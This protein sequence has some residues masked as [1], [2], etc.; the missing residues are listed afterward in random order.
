MSRFVKYAGKYF[1]LARIAA[2]SEIHV[3]REGSSAFDLNSYSFPVV[4]VYM[5]LMEKPIAV[6]PGTLDGGRH[7]MSLGSPPSPTCLPRN[8]RIS[9]MPGSPGL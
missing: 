1:D 2:I 6:Y 5:Q 8:S 4:E 3:G 9:G 7:K